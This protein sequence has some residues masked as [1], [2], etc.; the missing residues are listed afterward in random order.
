[1]FQR[2]LVPLDGGTLAECVLPVVVRIVRDSGSSIILLRVVRQPFEFGYG[3]NSM[4]MAAMTLGGLADAV[5]A[6]ATNYLKGIASSSYLARVNTSIEVHS[7]PAAIVI[8]NATQS[9][10]ID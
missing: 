7:G 4:P 3:N 6:N 9:Q 1:M 10:H 2:I 5:I 8:F